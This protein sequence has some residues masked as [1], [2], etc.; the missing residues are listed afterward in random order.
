MDLYFF[1]ARDLRRV[2][3][4]LAI[5]ISFIIGIG[6][7]V[8]CVLLFKNDSYSL[9]FIVVIPSVY[10]GLKFYSK[11][12][13]CKKSFCTRK[14][15]Q[16][17]LREELAKGTKKVDNRTVSTTFRIKDIEIY[18]KCDKCGFENSYTITKKTEV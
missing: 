5:F 10:F 6:V 18:T 12:P 7:S 2:G 8:S 16:E 3:R 1:D 13:N 4:L 9:L 14:T 17:T 11:C 15:G